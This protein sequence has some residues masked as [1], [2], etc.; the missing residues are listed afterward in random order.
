MTVLS[1]SEGLDGRRKTSLIFPN[2]LGD[3]L[4]FFLGFC[5]R[6]SSHK[7]AGSPLGCQL[8][9]TLPAQPDTSMSGEAEHGASLKT[10][11][12][13]APLLPFS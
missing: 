12:R 4:S 6:F 2:A 8:V 11:V 13:F 7:F 5:I 10:P 3:E 1:N 9:I